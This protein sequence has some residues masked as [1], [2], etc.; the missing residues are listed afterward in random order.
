MDGGDSDSS[1]TNEPAMDDGAG[2]EYPAADVEASDM[3]TDQSH[4]DG[5]EDPSESNPD[6]SELILS[7]N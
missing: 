2:P 6:D 4:D 7:H 3:D 5:S 1:E